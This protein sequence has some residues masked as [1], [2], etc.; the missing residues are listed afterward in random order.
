MKNNVDRFLTI[1][2]RK[3]YLQVHLV[4][5]HCQQLEQEKIKRTTLIDAAVVRMLSKPVV[6]KT[7]LPRGVIV[8]DQHIRSAGLQALPS[9]SEG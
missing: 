8:A 7:E 2:I 6:R 3:S 9:A 5:P 4:G 1:A